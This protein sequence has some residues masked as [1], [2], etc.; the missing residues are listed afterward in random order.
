MD[1]LEILTVSGNNLQ[2]PIPD[3][4]NNPALWSIDLTN[5]QLS[6]EI[7]PSLGSLPELIELTVE[8]NQLEG[9]LDSLINV[10]DTIDVT[11]FSLHNNGCFTATIPQVIQ[12]L[13]SAAPGWEDGCD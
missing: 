8:N 12:W 5:N 13:A 7:P 10:I 9:S 1:A 6:G 3:T 4:F 2:G 11:V